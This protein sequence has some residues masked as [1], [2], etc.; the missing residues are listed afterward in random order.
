MSFFNAYQLLTE[1]AYEYQHQRETFSTVEIVARINEI[2]Y[3]SS[4]KKVPKLSLRKEI[5]HLE[6][7]LAT[8]V[9]LE[10][11]M[12]RRTRQDSAKEKSLKK[13]IKGLQNRL[14]MAEDKDL[15][16][17]LDQLS[18][19]LGDYLAKKTTEAEVQAAI[20]E[21]KLVKVEK[22]KLIPTLIAATSEKKKH[23]LSPLTA[24]D[25]SSPQPPAE[26]QEKVVQPRIL[27]LQQRLEL[28]KGELELLK[29]LKKDSR[30]QGWQR[31]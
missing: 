16:K 14:A 23:T 28:L 17:K 8:V 3:L 31:R 29:I 1:A 10:Q 12:A 30:G 13:Q 6:N 5:I 21:I 27:Q 2:K 19:L 25:E 22:A 18:Q 11:R 26:I 7:K 4:Q 15:Q 20:A 9:E 24:A